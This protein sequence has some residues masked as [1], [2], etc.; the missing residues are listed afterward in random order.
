M[1]ENGWLI[2]SEHRHELYWIVRCHFRHTG[3]ISFTPTLN[4]IF[5][6]QKEVSVI[7]MTKYHFVTVHCFEFR[8][9]FPS[10]SEFRSPSPP[11]QKYFPAVSNL[12]IR[13]MAE[14]Q[15]DP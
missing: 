1:L 15:L 5:H 4:Y 12:N 10:T 8:M 14:M 3:R 11:Q 9:V 2:V 13:D 6:M 7:R